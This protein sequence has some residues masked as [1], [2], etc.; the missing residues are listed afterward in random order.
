MGNT[1]ASFKYQKGHFRPILFAL[2]EER[3]KC[4]NYKKAKFNCPISLAKVT[5]LLLKV[6]KRLENLPQEWSKGAFL[7]VGLGQITAFQTFCT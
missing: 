3:S 1:L 6:F 5:L 2:K 4:G 7:V